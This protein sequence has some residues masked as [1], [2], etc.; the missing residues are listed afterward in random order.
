MLN[1]TTCKTCQ[2]DFALHH[3]KCTKTV[4]NC[5]LYDKMGNCIK[6]SETFVLFKNK[7]LATSTIQNCKQLS[8]L[9]KTCFKVNGRCMFTIGFDY[10][11]C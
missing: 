10:T 2:T 1:A 6:C 8:T 3:N 5:R 7:C 11:R 4:P 9:K